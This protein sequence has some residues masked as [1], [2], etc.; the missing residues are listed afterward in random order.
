VKHRVAKAL[1]DSREG[2]GK[3]LVN[4]RAHYVNGSTGVTLGPGG[5]GR[6]PFFLATCTAADWRMGV[7]VVLG[8][9]HNTNCTVLCW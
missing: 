5:K 1:F 6:L 8:N 4:A 7:V 2:C 9:M 3:K